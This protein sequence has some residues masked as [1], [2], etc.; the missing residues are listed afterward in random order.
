MNT[1]LREGVA[2][3]VG[4]PVTSLNIDDVE[5]VMRFAVSREL[6]CDVLAT[7][8]MGRAKPET[9][10]DLNKYKN[11][12]TRLLDKWNALPMNAMG[13][14]SNVYFYEPSYIAL[15]A[16]RGFEVLLLC[17]WLNLS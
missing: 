14:K 9:L 2:V 7:I 5:G 6:G 8:S 4:V 1:L 12:L 17:S 16:S 13:Y 10:P 15:M 11:L 3:S